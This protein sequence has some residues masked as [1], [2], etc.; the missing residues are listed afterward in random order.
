VEG[1]LGRRES[2]RA[3]TAM[4]VADARAVTANGLMAY[5]QYAAIVAGQ[6]LYYVLYLARTK[7]TGGDAE[8]RKRVL[9]ADPDDV[10]CA[11]VTKLKWFTKSEDR[12]LRNDA[13]MILRELGLGEV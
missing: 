13:H 11:I 4:V 10:V 8:I 9:A 5:E 3:A 12:T 1:A 6:R 2:R 7:V